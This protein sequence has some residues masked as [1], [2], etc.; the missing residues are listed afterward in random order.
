MPSVSGR[1]NRVVAFGVVLSLASMCYGEEKGFH[2]NIPKHTKPTPVQQYNREGVAAL[3]K[4]NNEKAKKLFYKAYLLDPDD[5]FTLNNLGYVAELEGEVDAAQRFYDLAASSN[6]G[7][8]VEKATDDDV[9]GKA[10]SLVAGHNDNHTVQVNRYNVNAISLL[11]KNRTAEAVTV[12]EKALA[13]EPSNPF[14][15]NNMGYAKEQEGELEDA[16]KFYRRAADR[17][18]TDP[19]I[20]TVNKDWRGKEISR[21]AEE[22][23]QKVEKALQK[24]DSLEQQ[25]A[26]L[27]LRGVSALNR[28]DAEGARKNFEQAY[29]L[30]PRDSFTLN[31]MGYVSEMTGDKESADFYYG[32]A[33]EAEH[34]NARVTVASRHEVE[35][36]KVTEVASGNGVAV[37]SR[38]NA[39]LALR[40]QQRGPAVLHRRDNSVVTTPATPKGEQPIEDKQNNAEP[41]EN[42]QKE[43]Q[44][45][46]EPSATPV[47]PQPQ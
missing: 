25:V 21:I 42:Q 17:H 6:S 8:L 11:L 10:V 15:L 22:N 46:P 47:Q 14:T 27:N 45:N 33:R 28:N 41:N 39:E 34:A 16:V 1:T 32:K 18:S 35:G 26:R 40:R 38:M 24:S 30:D 23:A 3:K 4:H 29:R 37:D 20:V 19:V 5:P 13:I 7:A 43:P 9:T 44:Q 31:N 12:L 2:V 36:E